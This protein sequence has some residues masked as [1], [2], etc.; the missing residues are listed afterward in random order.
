MWVC[1][2]VCCSAPTRV[3]VT[4]CSLVK[5]SVSGGEVFN[6]TM[7]VRTQLVQQLSNHV[8]FKICV[9]VSWFTNKH[10]CRYRTLW[11]YSLW[12]RITN[13]MYFWKPLYTQLFTK[14]TSHMFLGVE[15]YYVIDDLWYL[16]DLLY[17]QLWNQCYLQYLYIVKLDMQVNF[18][19]QIVQRLAL[20][21]QLQPLKLELSSQL[22]TLQ[23]T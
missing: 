17:R 7:Y 22:L 12:N 15:L 10:C 21:Y 13:Y 20:W 9:L 16:A 8:L 2:L 6:Q 19:L 23:S 18:C 4:A 11:K 3:R 14:A 5:W 1:M